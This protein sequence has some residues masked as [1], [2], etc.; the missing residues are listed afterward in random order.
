MR[1]RD[2]ERYLVEQVKKHGGETIKTTGKNG[3]PDRLIFFKGSKPIFVEVKAPTKKPRALQKVQLQRLRSFDCLAFVI[4]SKE[5]VDA[6][7]KE[8]LKE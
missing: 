8:V 4:D 6:F 3:I 7:L 2:I 1:E 5:A